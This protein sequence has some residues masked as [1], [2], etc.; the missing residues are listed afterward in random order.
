[1]VPS[2]RAILIPRRSPGWMRVESEEAKAFVK[3]AGGRVCVRVF[4]SDNL[5]ADEIVR[6]AGDRIVGLIEGAKVTHIAPL[7]AAP[8]E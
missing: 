3:S 5:Q 1:M 6:L 2:T 7:P 4:T 8:E